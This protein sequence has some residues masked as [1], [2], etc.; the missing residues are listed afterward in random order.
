MRFFFLFI[1]NEPFY[2]I[3][4]P[5]V[6]LSIVFGERSMANAGI[7][8]CVPAGEIASVGRILPFLQGV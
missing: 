8:T 6:N 7:L 1:A 5:D 3:R 4:F 2:F